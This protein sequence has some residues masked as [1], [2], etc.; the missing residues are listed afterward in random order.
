MATRS[1]PRVSQARP[2]PVCGKFG[3]CQLSPDGAVTKCMRVSVG[4]FRSGSSSLGPYWLHGRPGSVQH[5]L[6]VAVESIASPQ[7]RDAV[8]ST[9]LNQLTLTGTDAAA[10]NRR[11]L[12][13]EAI[14][15]NSYAAVPR[16][17][18]SQAILADIS[19]RIALAG[20]PGLYRNHEGAWNLAADRGDLL[21]PIR[22]RHW[23]II[24]L[25]RRTNDTAAKYK[26]CSTQRTPSGA[27]VHFAEPW[28]ADFRRTLIVTEG[29]LK[30]DVIACRLG[31]ATIGLPSCH[32]PA[33]FASELQSEF[34]GIGTIFTAL[35]ADADTNEHVAHGRQRLEAIL[36]DAGFRVFRL[37]W[38]CEMGKGL[39]DLLASR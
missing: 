27:P 10:L 16:P 3:W 12:D 13:A 14:T 1:W 5:A 17:D 28:N 6:A 19:S 34:N 31:I 15:R 30:A 35:D 37:H 18:K 33:G 2:C 20:V 4:A 9:L 29:G 39:D 23:R 11:G 36:T 21:I 32:A 7:A 22:D 38:N 26:W 25:L 8:F 24:A